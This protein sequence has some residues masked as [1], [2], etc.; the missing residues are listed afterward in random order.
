MSRQQKVLAYIAGVVVGCLILMAIPREPARPQVHPWH[1]Q[2]APEGTY[3]MEVV[4]DLGRTVRLERQPRH[5]VSLAPSITEILFAMDM[6][7]HLVAVTQWCAFPE[8]A[9]A[10]RDSGAHVGSLDKPD[11]ETLAAYRPDLIIATDLTPP[12]I[13]AAIEDPPRTVALGL[14]HKDMDDIL[15]DIK[16]I[17]TATGVPGHALK[18]IER[19]KG[20]RAG[21]E[22]WLEP[23]RD[24]PARRVLFL[25]SIE[26]DGRPGWAPGRDAWV[27]NLIEA[28]HAV[29]TASELGTA[30]GEVSFENLL[31][32]DP[33]VLLI[34]EA[35]T[36]A[37]QD[38]ME[39]AVA[40]LE[41]H[42]VWSLVPAVR[43]G[44]VHF[45]PNGPLSIPGPRVMQAYRSIAEAVWGD[46]LN[47]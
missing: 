42:A 7:D 3:P 29:N 2:T 22:E 24:R 41:N 12:E 6:G 25:L 39:K 17:G 32:M 1:A 40:G 23:V 20:Q 18:L 26:A 47:P 10:L 31:A 4:D 28:A 16:L 30:W 46:A 36:P 8:A 14:V 35:D 33:D 37:G 45:V 44:R 21:V 13:F 38:R 5:F 34:R 43:N 11:R 27:T 15:E 19:L 9:R